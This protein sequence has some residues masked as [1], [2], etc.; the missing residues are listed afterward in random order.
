M[1][2]EHSGAWQSA[3]TDYVNLAKLLYGLSAREAAGG[4]G[5]CS[6]Y[7]LAGIPM[8]FSALRCLMIELD[9]GMIRPGLP[10][11]V[12]LQALDETRNDVI[13][14]RQRLQPS[15][16]LDDVQLLYEVRN[17]IIHPAH[18]PG[19]ERNGTPGYLLR[20]RDEG[21]LQTTGQDVDY[22]WPSQLH[23]H[24]LFRWACELFARLTAELLEDAM[25]GDRDWDAFMLKSY[26][27]FESY[28]S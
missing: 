14:L 19:P 12:A 16:L 26:S 17:E 13:A 8:L 18:R 10:N 9:G 6:A 22:P 5:N 28:A 20:L 24:R 1:V 23:S 2:E 15:T 21:L 3:S 4:D 11:T 7:V 27:D 25:T